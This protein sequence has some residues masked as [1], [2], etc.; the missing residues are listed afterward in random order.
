MYGAKYADTDTEEL[1]D[2]QY[3]L[4][5][6]KFCCTFLYYVIA[7]DHTIFVDLNIIATAQA[8]ATTTIMGDIFLILNYEETHPDA[9][10]HYHSRD[11]IRHVFSDV[12]YLYEEHACSRSGGHFFHADQLSEN[13]NKTPTLPINKKLSTLCDSS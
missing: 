10:L 6:K 4:Y 11:I 8:H 9:K 2:A 1:V 5:V 12:S 13:G 7:I 3:S